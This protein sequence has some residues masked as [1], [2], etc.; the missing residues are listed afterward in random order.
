M[1]QSMDHFWKKKQ[2]LTYFLSILV[3]FIHI[4]SFTYYENADGQLS[5]FNLVLSTLSDRTL[6]RCAVPLYFMLSG[7]LFFRDYSNKIYLKKLKSRVFSL[8][9][10]FL[11]WNTLWMLFSILTSYTPLSALFRGREKFLLSLPNVLE[12]IFHYSCNGPFWFVFE[13]M[14]FVLI[15][16]VFDLLLR[17]KWVAL[18]AAAGI[19][20]LD[21]FGMG[22]PGWLF[23]SAISPA[24]YIIGGIIG[25]YYFHWFTGNSTRK[26]VFF[27]S[28]SVIIF[29]FVGFFTETQ[30]L[31]QTLLNVLSY[32]LVFNSLMTLGALGLW[33]AADPIIKKWKL[34]HCHSTSFFVFAMHINVSAVMARLCYMVLPRNPA[35]AI[36]NFLLTTVLTL[37]F[38]DLFYRLLERL[39]PRILALLNG[40]RSRYRT[41]ETRV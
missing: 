38:I 20:V 28:I 3:F 15:S 19:L 24:H 39:V 35:F 2:I 1:Q 11:C 18:A 14:F 40:N 17:N 41:P 8:L 23:D 13:L 26:A 16:P 22:L 27:G 32:P 30:W 10:P 37:V 34:R 7:A 5:T 25:R 31:A 36:V 6:A 4:S 29:I 12:A 33:F 9:I 21:C